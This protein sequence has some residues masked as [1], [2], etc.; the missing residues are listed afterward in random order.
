MKT[1]EQK[2]NRANTEEVLHAINQIEEYVKD[3]SS[4]EELK[5]NS[6]TYDAVLMNFIL[7]SGVSK[8]LSES[9]KKTNL[10]ELPYRMS[11]VCWHGS[12][13]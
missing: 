5:S 3:S 6:M 11:S 7:I 9:L 4:I 2:L 10:Q 1:K 13:V 12:T 8:R